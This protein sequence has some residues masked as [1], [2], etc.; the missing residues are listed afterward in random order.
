[1]KLICLLVLAGCATAAP[2]DPRA[3]VIEL[4]R[5]RATALV[6]RDVAALTTI[7]DERFVYINASGERLDRATYLDR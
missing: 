6:A 7:L 2:G 3:T 1:M 5:A 4:A